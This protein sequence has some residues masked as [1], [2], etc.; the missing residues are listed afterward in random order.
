RNKGMVSGSEVVQLY[1]RDELASVARPVLELKGFSKIALAPGE[2]RVVSF[3]ITKEMLT[4]INGKHEKVAEPGMFRIMI[5]SS[6]RDLHLKTDLEL[7]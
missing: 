4:M 6:S 1:I 3:M 5:G 7:K 2:E